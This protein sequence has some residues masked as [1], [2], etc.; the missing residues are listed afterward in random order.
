MKTIGTKNS[1]EITAFSDFIQQA[2]LVANTGQAFDMPNAA[3]QINFTGTVGVDLWVRFGST[4]A[5]IPTTT[6]TGGS[7]TNNTVLNPG[8]RNISSTMNCTGYSVISATTG[9]AVM[10]FWSRG[11]T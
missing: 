7:T 11:S 5:A 3:G 9:V 10:E 8:L 1:A 4:A 6:T 2:V